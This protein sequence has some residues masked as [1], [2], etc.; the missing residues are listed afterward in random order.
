M[1]TKPKEVWRTIQSMSGKKSSAANPAMKS[2]TGNEIKFTDKD[3]AKLLIRQY[4]KEGKISVNNPKWERDI[5]RQ[6]KNHLG[7]ECTPCHGMRE[8][9][10][11][12]FT[13]RGTRRR[14]KEIEVD[15]V[16]RRRWYCK[17]DDHQ[18]T[19]GGQADGVIHD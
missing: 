14:H 13:K 10:C 3:K 4:E 7:K 18:L 2:G 17:R 5:R 9:E 12:V 16:T 1:R 15:D 11:H 6:W 19:E 8:E